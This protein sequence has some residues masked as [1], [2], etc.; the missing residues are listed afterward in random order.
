M[1]DQVQLVTRIAL[2]EDPYPRI[3]RAL[4]RQRGDPPEP[5]LA[6]CFP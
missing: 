5:G 6:S 4:L 3:E 2:G 1:N